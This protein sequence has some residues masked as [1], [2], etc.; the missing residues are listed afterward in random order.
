MKVGVLVAVAGIAGSVGAAS[1][2]ASEYGAPARSHLCVH[3]RSRR[4]KAT[5]Q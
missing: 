5:L 4:S 3:Q 2:P 1:A